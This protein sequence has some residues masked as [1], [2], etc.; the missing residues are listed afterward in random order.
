MKPCYLPSTSFK[1]KGH[2]LKNFFWVFTGCSTVLLPARV[3]QALNLNLEDMWG[4]GQ[5][6]VQPRFNGRFIPES[7]KKTLLPL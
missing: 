5:P 1:R 7:G 6:Q 2:L 3:V 4:N